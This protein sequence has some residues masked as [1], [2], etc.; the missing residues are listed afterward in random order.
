MR[1]AVV[2]DAKHN[3][4]LTDL[5]T[6]AGLKEAWL[7][8]TDEAEEGKWVTVA[9]DPLKYTNWAKGQPNNANNNEHY[10][11]LW[12]AQRGVW[13]DQ[14]NRSTAHR[15]GYICEWDK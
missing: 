12:A 6:Q 4:F 11:L 5:V 1:L 10:L 13:A 2:T 9:G 8:A 3:Q 14:P 7:G 15:P